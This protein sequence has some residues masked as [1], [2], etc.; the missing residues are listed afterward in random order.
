MSEDEDSDATNGIKRAEQKH[1]ARWT[2]A[3]Y[4]PVLSHHHKC[5]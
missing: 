1:C 5:L 2:E 4:R 3:K